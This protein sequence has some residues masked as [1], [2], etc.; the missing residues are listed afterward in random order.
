MEGGRMAETFSKFLDLCRDNNVEFLT[1]REAL[2][3]SELITSR[4]E[5]GYLPGR[6]GTL[7]VQVKD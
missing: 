2:A 7:A 5:A 6:A 3:Q 4:V 1:L